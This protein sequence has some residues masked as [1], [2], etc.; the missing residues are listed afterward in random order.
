MGQIDL[1]FSSM[2]DTGSKLIRWFSHGKYSHVDAVLPD[3]SLL[4]ARSDVRAGVPSGV[5]IRPSRYSVFS[6]VKRVSLPTI[7]DDVSQAFYKFLREQIG[8]PYDSL[9]I[10]AFAI[11]RNWRDEDAWFCAELLSRGLE[12]CKFFPHCLVTP[13]NRQTP[14]DLLLVLSALVEI[15]Q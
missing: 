1:Q 9:S 13:P 15:D 3:G 2:D 4:G 14:D 11:N 6:A 7:N 10:L 8:K 5:Q 12:V